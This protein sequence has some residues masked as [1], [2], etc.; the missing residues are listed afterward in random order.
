LDLFRCESA[1]LRTYWVLVVMDQFTRRIVGFAVH[2]G[3]VDGV[4]LCRMFNRAIHTQTLPK[5]LSSDHDPLYRFQQWQAN[6]RVLEIQEIKTVPYVPLSHPFV[7]RLIGTIRR[8]YLDQTLFWTAADLEEKLR[9][10]Q[11]YF[12]RHRVHSG[13]KGRLPEPG[14]STATLDFASYRWQQHCRGLYQTPIAA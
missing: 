12:N 6:L 8:E 11:D 9:A 5:Y 1:I 10:F 3:V 14:A 2:R 7:E 13:L 4:A